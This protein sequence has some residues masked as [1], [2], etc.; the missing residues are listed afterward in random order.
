MLRTYQG[1]C[2]NASTW[3]PTSTD[4]YDYASVVGIEITASVVISQVA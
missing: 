2:V 1:Q 3:F 4:R